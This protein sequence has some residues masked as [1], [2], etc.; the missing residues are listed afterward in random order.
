MRMCGWCM[1]AGLLLWTPDAAAQT[2]APE[3]T[4]T[5][6]P[7]G[8]V[9]V[10]HTALPPNGYGVH[11]SR[12]YEGEAAFTRLTETP[13]QA[14]R[15]GAAF[16]RTLGPHY[17]EVAAALEVDAPS[18]ALLRLRGNRVLANLYTYLY[19]Q[20]AD[21]LGRRYQDAGAEVGRRATYRVEVVDGEGTP[22]GETYET[23]ALLAPAPVPPPA[24][25]TATHDGARVTLAWS[26]P[27][28]RQ[29]ED[30]VYTFRAYR[31]TPD[32]P[33]TPL[34]PAPMLRNNAE[35]QYRFPFE[36]ADLGVAV[37]YRVVAVH[38]SGAES[39][40][41]EVTYTVPDEVP[42]MPP[43]DVVVSAVDGPAVEITW[44]VALE[45]DAAGYH[46]YRARS[47]APEAP[48]QRLTEVPVSVGD[49]YFLDRAVPPAR[50]Y[51]YE[52]AA[53][54]A[55]GNESRRS[56][57]ASVFVEDHTPPEAPAALH[58]DLNPDG[59]VTLT[60]TA[61]PAPDLKTYRVLRGIADQPG[62]VILNDT[63]LRDTTFIDRGFEQRGLREG[64]VY[65]FAVVALDSV[66]N[67]SDTT[68]VHFAYPDFT[69][70]EPPTT[71]LARYD[72]SGRVR[73]TWDA[74]PSDDAVR[75]RLYRSRPGAPPEPLT[76]SDARGWDDHTVTPG[77]QW[78]YA[79]SAVDD[80][81]NE[82]GPTRADTLSA[83][84]AVPPAAVR[85]V[86]A[87]IL[88]DGV[89]LVW[90]PAPEADVA[91]YRIYRSDL[92]TGVFTPLQTALFQ[93]PRQLDA[94]GRA[95][96]WYEV[97]AVDADGHESRPARPIQAR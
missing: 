88:D 40:P 17:D 22:T 86:R 61:S 66:Q 77:Q 96:L 62:N 73:V 51:F 69:P 72:G 3:V 71:V 91:G 89:L 68:E 75:Y 80:A 35:A 10:Y 83:R 87:A 59:A 95:G 13:L 64:T 7:D 52:V 34:L 5:V 27:Q 21:A 81:G 44:P 94:D 9:Y 50:T 11:L 8:T 32:G 16:V 29:A 37:T 55:S 78:I 47:A 65:R 46:V 15:Q 63:D 6:T 48:R 41:A 56:T 54:D 93:E 85:N 14:V 36:T 57:P 76:E 39:T 70:P 25:L 31:R 92:A 67:V 30:R 82:G 84:D 58:T 49:P 4:L 38:M 19:P 1:A 23:T 79:V 42:P 43:R 60:W 90:E 26:Y 97:R 12:R 28:G 18:R 20:V 74:S 33:E 2:V 24:G 53:L 45:A